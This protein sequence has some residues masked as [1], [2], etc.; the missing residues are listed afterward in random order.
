MVVHFGNHPHPLQHNLVLMSLICEDHHTGE[1][2]D[3]KV[4]DQRS[5]AAHS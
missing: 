3:Q 1:N 5:H 2:A 4:I